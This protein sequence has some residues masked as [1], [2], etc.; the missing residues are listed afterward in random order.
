MIYYDIIVVVVIFMK[1]I[2]LNSIKF[3]DEQ[4]IIGPSCLKKDIINFTSLKYNIKFI[5]YNELKNKYIYE[6]KDSALVYLDNKYNYIP[7]IGQIILN[8]LYEV[9]INKVYKSS[10]LNELVKIPNIYRIRLS[11]IE[12]NEI[13]DGIIELIKNNKINKRK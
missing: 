6:Y 9:D 10:K 12:I 11:S 3:K 4:I 5:D 7:E 13:T 8:N 1:N 2:D